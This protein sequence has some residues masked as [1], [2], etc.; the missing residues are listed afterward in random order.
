MIAYREGGATMRFWVAIEVWKNIRRE[1]VDFFRF[2]RYKV[3][4]R[5]KIKF[6]GMI[7]GLRTT[8]EG[9]FSEVV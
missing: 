1:W 8:L 6:C 7:C 5:S 2:V 9:S 4:D 3:G